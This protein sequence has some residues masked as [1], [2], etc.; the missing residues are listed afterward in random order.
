MKAPYRH[1]LLTPEKQQEKAKPTHP[2]GQKKRPGESWRSDARKGEERV[3]Q[4]QRNAR[5]ADGA[6]SA[7]GDSRIGEL[8][9]MGFLK[10]MKSWKA[11]TAPKNGC[12]S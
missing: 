10:Y 9:T 1:M 3:Q 4:D 6:D 12:D 5:Q 8:A 11:S 2:E 7:L